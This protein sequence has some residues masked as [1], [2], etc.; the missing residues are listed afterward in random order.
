[1][2][3]TIEIYVLTHK[4]FDENYD[5]SLY[6]PLLNGSCLWNND[7]GYLRDDSGDNISIH[8]SILGLE[9]FKGRYYWVLPL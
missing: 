1:M 2:N 4:K 8:R 9:E 5:S 6:K 7:Y 3:E